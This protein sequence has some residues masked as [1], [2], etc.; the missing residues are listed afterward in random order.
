MLILLGQVDLICKDINDCMVKLNCLKYVMDEDSEENASML[1]HKTFN[2]TKISESDDVS[3][4]FIISSETRLN[5]K[6]AIKQNFINNSDVQSSPITNRRETNSKFEVK[7]NAYSDHNMF[8]I[9]LLKLEIWAL[10]CLHLIAEDKTSLAETQLKKLLKKCELMK[11]T[12]KKVCN[13]LK[14]FNM[15]LK[16]DAL[17]RVPSLSERMLSVSVFHKLSLLHFIKGDLKLT[18]SYLD[19]AFKAL[20]ES[21][22]YQKYLYSNTYGLL[23]YHQTVVSLKILIGIKPDSCLEF[24]ICPSVEVKSLA[25]KKVLKDSTIL[26]VTPQKAKI[27]KIYISPCGRKRICK[28]PLKKDVLPVHI[29]KDMKELSKSNAFS[30]LIF[31]SS[32]DE[33]FS[34]SPLPSAPKKSSK[35]TNSTT[36]NKE[37]FENEKNSYKL[38]KSK[39]SDLNINASCDIWKFPDLAT[40]KVNKISK[41]N[42]V[43]MKSLRKTRQNTRLAKS[44]TIGS[45]KLLDPTSAKPS[46]KSRTSKKSALNSTK[47]SLLESNKDELNG[48]EE[49]KISIEHYRGT[50]KRLQ[51]QI[52][53][54]DIAM[55]ED[56]FYPDCSGDVLHS[57]KQSYTSDLPL[58]G[59]Y[60]SVIETLCDD[61]NAMDM[62]EN[63]NSIMEYKIPGIFFLL[64]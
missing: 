18:K 46:S 61:L 10:S 11:N 31:S 12:N 13:V 54:E 51:R 16:I 41:S 9:Y 15:D 6:R 28:A 29:K 55:E 25:A 58:E 32:D 8:S 39:N 63:I 62:T 50:S 7:S 33:L 64:I 30:S 14:T 27:P 3:E 60:S 45:S 35:K 57:K 43:A 36:L 44:D 23:K 21:S 38:F 49:R 19:S 4:D 42:Q 34:P 52:A 37:S 2:N 17:F 48:H 56:V 26:N 20:S 59:K 22:E 1:L 24:L 53:V 40:P 5:F 47:D